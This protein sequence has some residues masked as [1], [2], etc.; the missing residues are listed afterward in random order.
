VPVDIV[1]LTHDA[2]ELDVRTALER[3]THSGVAA[4]APRLI[5][6]QE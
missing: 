4:A 6:I 2:L 1:M 3:I 5:R